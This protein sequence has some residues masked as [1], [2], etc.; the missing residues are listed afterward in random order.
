[1]TTHD[2]KNYALTKLV[3]VSAQTNGNNIKLNSEVLQATPYHPMLTKQG[4]QK[5]GEVTLGQDVLCLYEQ[6]GNY[7]SFTVLLKTEQAG[8]AQKSL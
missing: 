6:T 1:M 3:L 2:A 7:E 8:G 5:I 4:N